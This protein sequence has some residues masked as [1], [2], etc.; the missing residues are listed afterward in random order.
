MRCQ[1]INLSS[2]QASQIINHTN[3]NGDTHSVYT[4][5]HTH[6]LESCV[7]FGVLQG[8]FSLLVCR[9]GL[10]PPLLKDHHHPFPKR[11]VILSPI[12]EFNKKIQKE[13]NE[14]LVPTE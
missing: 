9:T 7:R 14:S 13:L 1:E 11:E 10:N 4:N 6:T 12:T 3:D 5:N 8:E 2:C